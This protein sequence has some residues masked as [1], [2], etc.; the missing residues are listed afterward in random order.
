[1]LYRLIL[2]FPVSG[3]ESSLLCE[4]GESCVQHQDQ[5]AA[6][7]KVL[8]VEWKAQLGELALALSE[9]RAV[10]YRFILAEWW[11]PAPNLCSD[12]AGWELGKSPV[13]AHGA[14]ECTRA[15]GLFCH[16]CWGGSLGTV[17][18]WG[19][20]CAPQQHQPP[21]MLFDFISYCSWRVET[22]LEGEMGPANGFF[23]W[24]VA[25][26]SAKPSYLD[27]KAEDW[28]GLFQ[29]LCYQMPV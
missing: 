7:S 1:M 27:Y 29:F 26:I 22:N 28:N 11:G 17:G 3:R 21:K 15:L 18:C 4:L 6:R 5:G 13:P 14:G 24:N 9:K 25:F 16:H 23:L 8:A 12:R 19:G 2:S 20:Y 10:V